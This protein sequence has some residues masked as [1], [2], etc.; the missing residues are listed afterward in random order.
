M[1]AQVTGLQVGEF[2]HTLGDAH[3]Y[4][5]HFEQVRLQLTRSP[6]QLPR[7]VLNPDVKDIFPLIM[8]TFGLRIMTRILI[9]RE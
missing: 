6:R 9:F 8:M 3:V 2:V 4:H 5:N 1:M 7:M